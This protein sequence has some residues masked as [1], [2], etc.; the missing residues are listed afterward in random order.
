MRKHRLSKITGLLLGVSLI[1]GLT[2]ISYAKRQNPANENI[3]EI[4]SG[5]GGSCW[6]VIKWVKIV[7][8][9]KRVTSPIYTWDLSDL[10]EY[11]AGRYRLSGYG[12][13]KIEIW[14]ID[15]EG[16]SYLDGTLNPHVKGNL[17]FDDKKPNVV[18]MSGELRKV[19]DV[20][21]LDI[22]GGTATIFGES[23]SISGLSFSGEWKWDEREKNYGDEYNAVVEGGIKI[24]L[25]YKGVERSETFPLRIT[26]KRKISHLILYDYKAE[27]D[28]FCAGEE[29]TISSSVN[30]DRDLNWRIRI[31]KGRRTIREFSGNK[32]PISCKWDGKNKRGKPVKPGKYKYEISAWIEDEAGEK[33]VSAKKVSGEVTLIRVKI[34]S[35]LSHEIQVQRVNTT[36]F[37]W[38]AIPFKVVYNI[39]PASGWSPDKVTFLILKNG[40]PIYTNNNLP[41]QAGKNQKYEWDGKNNSGNLVDY[42]TYTTKIKVEKGMAVAESE[43]Y[44]FTVYQVN[45]GNT[46]YYELPSFPNEHAGL[47]YCYTGGNI[48]SELQDYNNYKI[49]EVQGFGHTVSV[50]RS[51]QEFEAYSEFRNIWTS[52]SLPSDISQQRR[53]RKQIIQ[54]AHRLFGIPYV[55]WYEI[56]D[57]LIPDGSW[58]GVISDILRLRC[59]GVTEVSYENA[60]N[61][62]F[63]DNDRWNIM[64]SQENLDYHNSEC[65]PKD[66]RLSSTESPLYLPWE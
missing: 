50:T 63:G 6:P 7:I 35:D 9:G 40:S 29:T 21:D 61:R 44:S 58:D 37:Q 26:V 47:I 12:K 17:V 65:T 49:C 43:E 28:V 13:A 38:E 64:L 15:E 25:S 42:G 36:S 53:E 20:E 18:K 46:V 19:S 34:V 23:K 3:V 57:V 22:V 5:S 11:P 16:V 14:C 62:L 60:G 31:K 30:Y 59:D 24:T 48:L 4:T 8:G 32:L 1:F 52:V 56:H 45:V 33:I 2:F 51:L 66:Q 27:P 41:K 54:N 55:A 39:L 10:K